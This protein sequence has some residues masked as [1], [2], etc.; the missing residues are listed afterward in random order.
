MIKPLRLSF[1]LLIV[2]NAFLTPVF[3]G[4]ADPAVKA[5][6][7]PVREWAPIALRGYGTLSGKHEQWQLPS[8]PASILTI[9]CESE[10]K[11]KIVH[12][13]YL[14]DLTVV[15]GVK[16][17]EASAGVPHWELGGDKNV[18]SAARSRNDVLIFQA[19][20]SGDLETLIQQHVTG[21]ASAL[22]FNP[23]AEEPMF[24]DRWDK[25]G[26][27]FYYGPWSVPPGTDARKYDFKNDFD[28]ADKND[29]SGLVIWD[30]CHDSDTAAGIM[31]VVHWQASMEEARARKLPVAINDS[32]SS[33]HWVSN[34]YRGETMMRAPG[35]VGSWGEISSPNSAG[36]GTLSW[37]SVDGRNAVLSQLQSTV[38]RFS[39]YPNLVSWLEPDGEVPLTPEGLMSD[40][41][42]AADSSYRDYLKKNY[43]DLTKL[44]KRW[45][46][47]AGKLT[48]WDQVHVPELAYFRGGGPGCIDL[49]GT[50]KIGY[51]S[52]PNGKVYTPEEIAKLH[53]QPVPTDPAPED[54]YKPDFDDSTW[55]EIT[56]PGHDIGMFIQKRPAVFRRHFSLDA[57]VRKKSEHW[58]LYV[59]DLNRIHDQKMWAYVNGTKVGESLTT[60][61][62][63]AHWAAFEVT[64]QLQDGKNQVSLRLPEGFIGYRVYLSSLPV[65]DYPNLGEHKN[66]EW[67][68]FINWTYDAHVD[69]IRRGVEMIRQIDPNR[70][71]TFMHPDDMGDGLKM[72]SEDYGAEFHCTGYMSG[73]FAEVEPMVMRGSD[74]PSSLE[75]GGPAHTL[76]EFKGQMGL[77]ISEGVQCIDYFLHIGDV[78]WHD[79][80]RAYFEDHSKMLH[81]VGKYHAPKAEVAMLVDDRN[82]NLTGYPW[83]AD[84]NVVMGSGYWYWNVTAGLLELF[85]YDAVT[86]SDFSRGNAAPYKVII[87]SNTSIMSDEMVSQIEKYVR[88]GGVFITFVETGRHSPTKLDAWPIERLTGYHV[89]HIDKMLRNNIPEFHPIKPAPG[90][91]VFSGDD[92]CHLEDP[93]GGK[94]VL[95]N[96]LSM[97]KVASDGQDLMLW[98]DGKTAIGMRPLGKGYIVEVG[99]KFAAQQ[100]A[101]RWDGKPR[102]AEL[103][104]QRL[105]VSLL[106][107]FKVKH[108]PATLSDPFSPVMWRH[109][110]SNNGL[111]DVWTLSNRSKT[112]AQTVALTFEQG[113]NPATCLEIKNEPVAVPITQKDGHSAIENLAFEPSETRMFITPRGQVGQAPADWFDL[114]RHWWRGTTPIRHELPQVASRFTIDQSQDWA[115]QPLDDASKVEEMAAAGYDDSKC[116]RRPL[117]AW[118]LSDH[119]EVK[120]ALLRKVITVPAGWN[121][122]HP[123][124]WIEGWGNMFAGTG[125]IFFDGKEVPIHACIG[126]F[127]GDGTLK[128]GTKHVVALE[129]QGDGSL[130]GELF[131]AWISYLPDP[132]SSIDLSGDWKQSDD[133]LTYPKTLKLPGH[134]DGVTAMKTFPVDPK[135][136]GKNIYVDF[137][138]PVAV[139]GLM[140]N[141]VWLNHSHNWSQKRWLINITPWVHFGKDNELLLIGSPVPP[142]D[143]GE[144]TSVKVDLYDP[145]VYP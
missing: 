53:H 20:S 10:E 40:F 79:D 52:G 122:G 5:A 48:S 85:H 46:G 84:L 128:A 132:Q 64:S 117:G 62:H 43:Q 61:E 63:Q 54:W 33:P 34:A 26:F 104:T 6:D 87:D 136:K 142:R 29:R 113:L 107:H 102:D 32:N 66:A 13:K 37:G 124:F 81:M 58:Y 59:W 45:Y 22:V 51:E 97:E 123:Y 57:E 2:S 95:P 106:D 72:V 9:H 39:S 1:L 3:A 73:F 8:G 60:D 100:I 93:D 118:G 38:R 92:W 18:F 138:G 131:P 76:Q 99:V 16:K 115:F 27:R 12:A 144:V 24:L 17:V 19:G 120:H 119:P 114:Q 116:E 70:P 96:G 41:G 112:D 74:L 105:F 86:G 109:Y 75:P 90:Q 25:F 101:D 31:D 68:D 14:S 137:S 98:D 139:T 21:D 125:R 55:P 143:D 35:Y 80:I 83:G 130:V 78:M 140:I 44:S 121:K 129:I 145:A 36:A 126:D 91:D 67:V 28:F 65:T 23:E 141:G 94:K 71:I 11:A 82:R 127:D 88:D 15:P 49:T 111:Y 4:D 133:Y 69:G 7:A 77:N 103:M 134:W 56:A 42:P 89:S 135:D 110:V 47:E 50:W 30:H 108:L